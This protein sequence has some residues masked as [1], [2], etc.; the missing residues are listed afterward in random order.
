M[1][2]WVYVAYDMSDR[3]LY[4]GQTS[5]LTRRMR[6]HDARSLWMRDASYIQV[7]RVGSRLE[8]L[9]LESRRIHALQPLHNSVCK[10]RRQM[11]AIGTMVSIGVVA[12]EFGVS[13]D[14]VRNW[15]AQGRIKSI[16]TLGGQRRYDIAQVAS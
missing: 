6:Q 13:T 14:T 3:V 5:D 10:Q 11:R 4:V 1:N 2:F 16:R 12:R 7:T 9:A 8:A 15:E